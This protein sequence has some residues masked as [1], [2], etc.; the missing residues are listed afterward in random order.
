MSEF[1]RWIIDQGLYGTTISSLLDGIAERF[2]ADGMPLMRAYLALPTVNPAFRVLNH[3]WY[4]GRRTVV[5]GIEHGRDSAAFRI[6][7]FSSMLEEGDFAR[8]WRIEK[9]DEFTIF[10]DLRQEGGTDYVARLVS[11]NNRT[12]PGLRGLATSFTSDD[13]AGFSDRDIERIDAALP[14]VAL[15]AYRIALLDLAVGV[16]D[17]Y[18]G[19][20]AGRRVL[21]GEMHRGAGETMTAA[22]LFADLRGFSALADT[23]GTDLIARLDEHLEAV[24][25]PVEAHGGEV[26]K[27]LGDGLLAVFPISNESSREAA[28]RAALEASLDAL[29]NTARINRGHPPETRLDLDVALHD[30]DVFYGNIGGAK[31]LDFTVIGP[32]V[33]EVSRIEALCA[34]LGHPLLLSPSVAGACGHPMRSVGRHSLRGI[35]GERELFT[36]AGLSP[37]PA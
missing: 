9:S 12:A 15:S 23:H 25:G 2:L 16:L 10:A 17:T 37:E 7:P 24:T 3:T 11:F 6:S 21:S 29:R 36:L 19:F 35:A 33:N 18:V 28:C 8:R 13:P 26:L 22:L 4:R 14:L 31:R 30:G 1:E 32:A 20:S 27:F 5:E 34:T